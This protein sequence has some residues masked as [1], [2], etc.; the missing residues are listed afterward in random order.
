MGTELEAMSMSMTEV[1]TVIPGPVLG[2]KWFSEVNDLWPG[3]SFSLK[4]KEVV[5]HEKSK[6]QDI[7]VL[8][9]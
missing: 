5:H 1:N 7:L 3:Q 6:F 2:P 4:V 8:E 9:R